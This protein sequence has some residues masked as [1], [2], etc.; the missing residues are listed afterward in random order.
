MMHALAV[1]R[2]HYPD[3]NLRAIGAR[4]ARGT[5]AMKQEQL[6]DEVGDATKRLVGDVNLFGEVYGEGQA[7]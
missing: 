5:G 7:Q 4:F 1:V 2:S 3:I 6:K